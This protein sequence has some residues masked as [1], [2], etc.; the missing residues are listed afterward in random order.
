[1]PDDP[2]DGDSLEWSTTSP[3]PEYD[4]AALPVVGKTGTAQGADP[5]NAQ[6]DSSLFVGFGPA[7]TAEQPRYA[8]GAIIEKG[9][10]GADGAAA[11]V[12]CVFEALSGQTP[13]DEPVHSVPLDRNSNQAAVL[14]PLADKSCLA[15]PTSGRD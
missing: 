11:I 1:V 6:L 3:P 9:G 13:M 14:P 5:S 15:I 12:K 8:V 7:G 2:W 4:F 10:F